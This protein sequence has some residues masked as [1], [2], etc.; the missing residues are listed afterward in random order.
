LE[1]DAGVGFCAQNVAAQAFDRASPLLLE[2]L[3]HVLVEQSG[4]ADEI[5]RG[6][7]AN[8]LGHGVTERRA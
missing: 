3:D 5:F 4:E 6:D 7:G 8:G 2:G 1:A